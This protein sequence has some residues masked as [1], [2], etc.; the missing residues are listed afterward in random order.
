AV[1]ATHRRAVSPNRL[2]TNP[3]AK[4]FDEFVRDRG[5][6]RRNKQAPFP[7]RPPTR[8]ELD[9]GVDPVEHAHLVQSRHE[10]GD[11]C[12]GQGIESLNRFKGLPQ[13]DWPTHGSVDD[14]G[15]PSPER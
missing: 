15:E 11:F 12:T 14:I 4:S 8:P 10:V 7:G 3:S 9:S 2:L 1:L 6:T 5:G 13:R